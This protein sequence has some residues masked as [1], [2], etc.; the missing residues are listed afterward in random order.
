MIKESLRLT[1]GVVGKAPRV[2]PPEGATLCGKF[3]PGGTIVSTS[4]Y[5][6]NHN[7]EYFRS[8]P[9][10]QFRPE[11]WLDKEEADLN[12]KSFAPF[13]RGSR[14]CIGQNL[15]LANLHLVFAYLFRRFDLEIFETNKED[16]E[17]H[18]GLLA[19]TFG[20]LRVKARRKQD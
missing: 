17:W 15:A 13:S 16:M 19:L 20:H 18:D 10:D 5:T 11:R 1:Y 14:N 6:N 12:E 2:V 9:H 4:S 7:P 3:V 8:H